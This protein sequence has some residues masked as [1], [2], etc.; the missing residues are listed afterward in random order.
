MLVWTC[1]EGR[2]PTAPPRMRARG[3]GGWKRGEGEETHKGGGKPGEGAARSQGY[4]TRW[5]RKG[6]GYKA[7]R[8]GGDGDMAKQGQ[9]GP[10]GVGGRWWWFEGSRQPS[11]FLRCGSSL[12]SMTVDCLSVFLSSQCGCG[13]DRKSLL[14]SQTGSSWGW[15]GRRYCVWMEYGAREKGKGG[16]R[17]TVCLEPRASGGA[18]VLQKWCARGGAAHTEQRS[19]GGSVWG[20]HAAAGERRASSLACSAG[21]AAAMMEENGEKGGGRGCEAKSAQAANAPLCCRARARP[22][23]AA[24]G[25]AGV[26]LA[27]PHARQTEGCCALRNARRAPRQEKDSASS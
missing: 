17:S 8:M 13:E 14:L 27:P 19:D 20:G 3:R 4:T 25:V 26:V 9:G 2:L 5:G 22:S 23:L 11:L 6:G 7:W 1:L 18:A 24:L 21:A 16:R 10:K 12:F 15:Q